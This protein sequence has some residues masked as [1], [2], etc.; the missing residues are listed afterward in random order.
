M[1]ALDQR[2]LHDLSLGGMLCQTAF[3][4][5]E[6]LCNILWAFYQPETLIL[7][8]SYFKLFRVKG[9]FLLQSRGLTLE[10]ILVSS[11]FLCRY[12]NDS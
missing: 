10:T 12:V 9:Y 6:V 3:V 8:C 5:A 4:L 1:L 11:E 2:I 7:H